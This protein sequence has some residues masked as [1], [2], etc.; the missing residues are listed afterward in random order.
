P[1]PPCSPL[2]IIPRSLFSFCWMPRCS[3]EKK[4]DSDGGFGNGGASLGGHGSS[5][6]VAEGM[7]M[8]L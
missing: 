2:S 7:L 8:C 4:A 1:P 3:V 6:S 5:D